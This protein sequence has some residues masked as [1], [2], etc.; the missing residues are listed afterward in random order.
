[1]K[2]QIHW[3]QQSVFAGEVTKTAAEDLFDRLE[4]VVED[5]R[6]TFWMF[7]RKPETRHIGEQDDE[8]S[9]FL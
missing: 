9:I 6:V 2:R 3:I 5:A 1:L 8:E 7:E 4:Q